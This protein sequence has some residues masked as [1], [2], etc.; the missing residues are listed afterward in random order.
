M[1]VVIR[2][3]AAQ[4]AKALSS[5]LYGSYQIEAHYVKPIGSNLFDLSTSGL[6]TADRK[7]D[8]PVST[9]GDFLGRPRVLDDHDTGKMKD[10]AHSSQ[11]GLFFHCAIS[12]P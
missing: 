5:Q 1:S 11:L 6:M 12:L 7:F 4:E 3:S 9:P 8:S 10:L 2:Y